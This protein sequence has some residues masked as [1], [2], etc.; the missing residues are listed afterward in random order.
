MFLTVLSFSTFLAFVLAQ[1]NVSPGCLY[2]STHCACRTNN[3]PGT[4]LRKQS[5]ATSTTDPI[6]TV[7][8]CST[9]GYSCDCLGSDICKLTSCSNWVPKDGSIASQ[10]TQGTAVPCVRKDDGKCLSKVDVPVQ[11]K[12][13]RF[14]AGTVN[15]V[16][17]TMFNMSTLT[18]SNDF[19][20]TE[21]NMADKWDHH[22]TLRYRHVTMRLYKSTNGEMFL[23][24]IYNTY[25]VPND[26]L[27]R[28]KISVEIR[29]VG[30][31]ELRWVACDDRNECRGGGSDVLR[32]THVL[33][34]THS[35]GW[36]VSPVESQEGVTVKF[37]EMDGFE[38]I[39]FQLSDGVDEAY[40]FMDE[41]EGGVVGMTG[42]V[43]GNGLVKGGSMGEILFNV[44]GIAVAQG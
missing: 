18:D 29:S 17:G 42:T 40:Y 36:C 10:L 30:G 5:D 4:C 23:C 3:S 38:G 39:S 24:G 12:M 22:D 31:E 35:D 19:I 8:S 20:T 7:T 14:G 43:D 11:Y 28:M 37:S 25:G 33:A 15:N 44:G 21:Y 9:G 27:G 32:A 1:T 2:N 16:D 13:V 26:G 41:V 34:F 6:C